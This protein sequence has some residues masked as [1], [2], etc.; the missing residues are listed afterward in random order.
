[1]T[2]HPPQEPIPFPDSIPH[3]GE[4]ADSALAAMLRR[5]KQAPNGQA[6]VDSLPGDAPAV[7]ANPARRSLPN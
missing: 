7:P 6:P 4:G 2:N 1:M 3:A 5:R